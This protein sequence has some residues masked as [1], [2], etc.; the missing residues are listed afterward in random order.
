[1]LRKFFGNCRGHDQGGR[2]ERRVLVDL[3]SAWY[4]RIRARSITENHASRARRGITSS[5]LHAQSVGGRKT[6]MHETRAV[7]SIHE[8]D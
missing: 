8:T 7:H 5:D 4:W 3:C 6:S 2:S 1:M